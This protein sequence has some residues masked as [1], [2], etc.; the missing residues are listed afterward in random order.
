MGKRMEKLKLKYIKVRLRTRNCYTNL[1]EENV[2]DNR[3][4][5]ISGCQKI[6]NIL[7]KANKTK[8]RT[9]VTNG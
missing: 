4:S 8:Y 5:F 9:S 2:T 7:L 6:Y 1:N 3:Q